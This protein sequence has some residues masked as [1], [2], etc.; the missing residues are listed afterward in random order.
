MQ[1]GLVPDI[2]YHAVMWRIEHMVQEDR[3]LDRS[4]ARGKVFAPGAHAAD[5]ELAKFAGE[6]A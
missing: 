3:Q 5:E 2:P 6:R 4:Q 1:I